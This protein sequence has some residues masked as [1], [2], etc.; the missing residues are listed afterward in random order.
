[1]RF[2]E[3]LRAGSAAVVRGVILVSFLVGYAV[4]SL[5]TAGWLARLR[6]VDLRGSGSKNPGANNASRLGGPTLGLAVLVVEV[7]KGLLAVAIGHLMGGDVG[8]VACGVGAIG[9][10]VY[11]VW[12]RFEGGKGLSITA[13]VLAGAWPTVLPFLLALLVVVTYLT[14]SSGRGTLATLGLLSVSSLL[15]GPLDLSTAWG[16]DDLTLLPV[17]GVGASLL[18]FQKHF[19]DARNPLRESAP[20]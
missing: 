11:N 17:L 13:G 19:Y 7:G 16:I 4:G 9:G 14:R 18:L 6:G 20:Q 8:A 15:W 1:M 10:N 5:P 3:V 12:Y 2:L